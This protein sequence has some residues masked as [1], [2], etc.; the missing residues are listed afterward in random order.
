MGGIFLVKLAQGVGKMRLD[1]VGRV[2]NITLGSTKAFMPLFE[3][4]V[5]LLQAIE[6]LKDAKTRSI[7]I[8]VQRDKNNQTFNMGQEGSLESITGFIVED[9]GIGFT[10]EN[11]TAFNTSD[12]T[13]KQEKGGKGVG[14]FLWLKAFDQVRIESYFKE[15]NEIWF[16]SFDFTL[17]HE[18]GVVN[19][20]CVKS[21]NSDCNT[22]VYLIGLKSKYQK[23]CQKKL[24]VIAGKIIEHCLSYFLNQN[25]PQIT[26]WND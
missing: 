14:R 21:N 23:E 3:A 12:T 7:N 20:E 8:Y 5:N 13:T 17:N 18:D 19:H 11:Y 26:I 6:D 10:G 15:N 16:R 1:L 9:N 24:D 25:C 2:N 4:V 22:R